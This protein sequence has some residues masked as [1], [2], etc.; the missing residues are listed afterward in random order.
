MGKAK[1]ELISFIRESLEN[2]HS[3]KWIESSL[4]SRGYPQKLA[5][6]VIL[7]YKHRGNILKWLTISFLAVILVLSIFL[8][9]SGILGF[10]AL[11][12]SKPSLDDLNLVINTTS[13]Y[14]WY[15]A[16]K[17]E[18]TSL[19]ITGNLL[20]E[21]SAKVYIENNA[22]KY[23]I[24]DSKKSSFKVT[25]ASSK[26]VGKILH[27]DSVCEQTC[28]LEGFNKSIYSLSFEIE[29]SVLELNSISYSVKLNRDI[30]SVPVFLKIPEQKSSPNS[31][32]EIDLS[33]F[34]N[35]SDVYQAAVKF[36]FL[37][38]ENSLNVSISDGIAKLMP[39]KKGQFYLYFIAEIEGLT[40]MSNLIKIDVSDGYPKNKFVEGPLKK[41]PALQPE[42]PSSKP[43]G[44]SIFLFAI[45]L[46]A[47]IVLAFVPSRF[48]N[49]YDI[50]AKLES[51]RKTKGITERLS[52]YS[53]MKKKLSRKDLK[54][55]DKEKL[56]NEMEAHLKEVKQ[57]I[58]RSP[59][60][61][62]FNS[63]ADLFESALA[64]N[65]ER[66]EKLYLELRTLYTRIAKSDLP[67][68]DKEAAYK[69]IKKFYIRLK[70]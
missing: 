67:D 23:L 16:L 55:E 69:R 27:L 70:S 38:E 48:F 51:I 42:A 43:S 13:S 53:Q 1:R 54:G 9:G 2:G 10:V 14:S 30:E 33:S 7:S 64:G 50:A 3:F 68:S 25:D 31:L 32:L 37:S 65:K 29:N 24:F 41:Q 28:S 18:I 35:A 36:S 45:I 5:E 4:I 58:P 17:G 21:G 66:A 6:G 47:I 15:P 46:L 22:N 12:Y 57:N 61:S 56:L 26:L 59:L 11:E 40:F 60:L 19:G 49:T 20:G 62:E 8:S 52:E 63:K 39:S 34:F 44:F